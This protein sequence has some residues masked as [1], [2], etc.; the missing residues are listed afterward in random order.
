MPYFITIVQGL[1][2]N[3]RPRLQQC[4]LRPYCITVGLGQFYN[5]MP[6]PCFTKIATTLF[7]NNRPRPYL[8]KNGL[9]IGPCDLFL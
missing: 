6:R 1:I 9:I 8:I 5:S 3:S 4:R 7:Y 2:L